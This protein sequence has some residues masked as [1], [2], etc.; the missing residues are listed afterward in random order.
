[1]I[2]VSDILSLPSFENVKLQAACPDAG[3]REVKNVGIVDCP[4]DYNGYGN[5]F[6]GEFIITNLGFAY[7]DPDLAE[8]SLLALIKRDVSGIAVK[9]VYDAPVSDNVRCE[10]NLA[11]VPVYQYDGAFHEQIAYEALDL[12]K[13]DREDEEHT[14]IIEELLDHYD[15]EAVKQSLHNLMG[16]TGSCIQCYALQARNRDMLSLYAMRDAALAALTAAAQD[17]P[18]I[19]S[20]SACRY[21]DIVLA[22]ICYAET[23]TSQALAAG[24]RCEGLLTRI[25]STLCGE[26]SIQPLK[27][28]DIAIRQAI[29][30]LDRMAEPDRP[31]RWEDRPLSAFALAAAH[32]RL[33]MSVSSDVRERLAD[34]DREHGS[35]LLKTAEILFRTEGDIK[36]SAEDLFQHPNTV[37]YRIRKMK[38]LM[39]MQD[40]SDRAFMNLLMLTFLPMLEHE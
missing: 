21:K 2:T 1:M 4:P 31:G 25:D 35:D 28:G 19:D 29:G 23:G 32:D 11:G 30:A 8:R 13:R 5:Y 17:H 26:G 12:I 22:L 24:Q 9:R 27:N 20:V 37:R 3:L 33:Y 14:R 39:G 40:A 7:A 18:V 15:N 10:S 34:Y 16:A 6:P 36:S 38:A